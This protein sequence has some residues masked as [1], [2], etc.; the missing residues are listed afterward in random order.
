MTPSAYEIPTL[1][2]IAA[3]LDDALAIMRSGGRRIELVT[4]L[5]EGGFTPSWGL[6]RSLGDQITIPVAVMLRP[7]RP[8]FYYSA[9]DLKEMRQDIL[10]FQ[11]LGVRHLVTGLLDSQGVADIDTLEELLEGTPFTLTFHRAIDESADV[12]QSLDRINACGRITHLLTSLGRGSVADNLDR[13]AW[14]HERS[15]PRLILGG[16][17]TYKNASRVA[18]AARAYGTDIHLGSAIRHGQAANPVDP[19]LVSVFSDILGL[20]KIE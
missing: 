11:E 16:G 8:A 20:E 14:Y 19:V 1:E 6:V 7:N 18:E 4:A 9:N 10:G 12:E 2:C 13:L 5:A 17:I 3:S 15:R